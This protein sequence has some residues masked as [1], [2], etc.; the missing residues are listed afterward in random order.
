M[1]SEIILNSA[2]AGSETK[3]SR[4]AGRSHL[5]QPAGDLSKLWNLGIS[6]VPLP[7]YLKWADDADLFAVMA[8]RGEVT[9]DELVSLTPLTR[10]GAG[11]LL[12]VLCALDIMGKEEE[13]YK[14]HEVGIHYLDKRS[15]YYVGE[16]LFGMF[17]K[18]IPK[19]LKRSS[20]TRHYSKAIGSLWYKLKSLR[21]KYPMGGI[22]RLT[23]QHSRNFPASVA[24]S[25]NV[26]FDG[27]THLVDIAG[28][29][30]VFAIPLAQERPDL[31]ITLVELPEAL[32]HVGGFLRKYGVEER[33]ELQGF[34]VHHIPWPVEECDGVLFGNFLHSCSDNECKAL[35]EESFRILPAGGRVFIHEMLWNENKD[36]PLVTALWNFWLVAISAGGQRTL[37]EFIALLRDA[38]FDVPEVTATQGG[39]S[40]LVAHKPRQGSGNS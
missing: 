11:A 20:T 40:L 17:D 8:D 35:L 39:F 30:G 18:E 21:S 38:G 26:C 15:P 31:R 5:P 1:E 25:H 36:G 27:L 23:I 34:N 3:G 16:S 32:P 28:G 2:L 37:A 10:R 29:S 14:L 9:I 33:I 13:R 7:Q 24:A 4:H 12:G 22:K 6:G 19:R